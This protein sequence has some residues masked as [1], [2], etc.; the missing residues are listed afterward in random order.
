VIQVTDPG[1]DT[2]FGTITRTVSRTVVP[3]GTAFISETVQIPRSVIQ[4]MQRARDVNGQ[5]FTSF[6][7]VRNFTDNTNTV[8]AAVNLYLTGG[9]G[10]LLEIDRLALSFDDLSTERVVRK[11]DALKALVDIRFSGSGQLRGVW[12]LA[13]PAST[14]GEPV[15]SAL[16][17]VRQSL[18]GNQDTRIKSPLLPTDR[19]GVYLVRFL[20]TEP[21]TG[22]D[23][24][25]IRYAVT[26]AGASERPR[27]DVHALA[28]GK[29]ALI[30]AETAFEWHTD[31]Q[32]RAWKLEIY[33]KPA[34][35]ALDQLPD[36]GTAAES[37]AVS[38]V[39]GP[40]LTGML[41]PGDARTTV[42]SKLVWK[43]LESGRGYWW[44]LRAIGDDG[45][46]IG[47]SPLVE[48][49]SP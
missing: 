6:I 2:V 28:P 37:V 12:E 36:L 7:L 13:T 33:P 11:E 3:G 8:T 48:F 21:D 32:P 39:D 15:F 29:G 47:E 38:R 22:F 42:L 14:I 18:V 31:A 10:S 27:T 40:P 24:V 49:R 20:V 34:A 19:E 1:Q 41:L 46:V 45:S 26:T 35:D 25:Y 9:A 17:L 23:P 5:L 30:T 43:R 44:R 16:R 4:V